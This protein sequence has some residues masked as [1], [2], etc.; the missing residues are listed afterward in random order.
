MAMIVNKDKIAHCF[1]K[2]I[3]TYDGQATVQRRISSRLLT[4]VGQIPAI[5][6][7]RVLEIGCCTGLLTQMLCQQQR[8]ETLFLND[9]VADFID[10]VMA[11]IPE[12]RMPHLLPFF[13]DI[14]KL[15]L[16][17]RISLVLS[18]ATFQWLA[19]LPGLLQRL[20]R[21]LRVDGFLIFSIFGPGTLKEF[22]ELTG[23]GLD[24]RSPEQIAGLLEKDYVLEQM[25]TE[26]DQLVL[27]TPRDILHHLRATGVGGVRAYR[28]TGSG[29]RRF[30]QEYQARF[31]MPD[32]V[33]ITYAS[34]CFI[35]RKK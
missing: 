29:L 12:G 31:G 9:L 28:W 34:T 15:P 35:A 2:A 7:E 8:V 21:A 6:Y 16:P 32:G 26:Q 30:E 3:A 17:D 33:P 13:G 1:R 24:Y 5:S 27:P 19:D 18:S 22:T 23:I 4:L 20:A 25:A 14:E 11:G 10:P